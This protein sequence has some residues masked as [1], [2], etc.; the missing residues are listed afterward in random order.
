[1]YEALELDRQANRGVDEGLFRLEASPRAS[2]PTPNIMNTSTK[3]KVMFSEGK[4]G[5]ICHPDPTHG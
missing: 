3:K 4:N 5:L 1:M 2:Q